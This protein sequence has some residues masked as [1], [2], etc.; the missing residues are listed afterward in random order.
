MFRLGK[1]LKITL[2]QGLIPV[3][4]SEIRDFPKAVTYLDDN[5]LRHVLSGLKNCVNLRSCTW[6]REGSLNS[7]ILEALLQCK[8]LRE[9][10]LNGHNIGNYDPRL[11]LKFT[12]LHRISLIMPTVPVV[13]QLIPWLSATGATL[14]SLTLICK[15]AHEWLSP[16]FKRY[17]ILHIILGIKHPHRWHS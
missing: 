2:A 8:N 13:S 4:L 5:I 3:P 10:E 6:T 11:L 7:D 16:S 15:V 17:L 14:R 12:E 1:P 9:L